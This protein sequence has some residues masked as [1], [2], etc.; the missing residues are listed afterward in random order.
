ML[1]DDTESLSKVRA[2]RER[3]IQAWQRVSGSKHKKTPDEA[4]LV[5]GRRGA[6]GQSSATA[7]HNHS[8]L[9][10]TA[11]SCRLIQANFQ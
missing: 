6:V 8:E 1:Q 4:L 5:G 10:T 3:R 11:E 7:L 9:R 2:Q